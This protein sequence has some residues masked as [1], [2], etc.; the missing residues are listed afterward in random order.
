MREKIIDQ[1]KE[2]RKIWSAYWMSRP[3]ITGADLEVFEHL[4][5]KKSAAYV[6]K[7]IK[8]APRATEIL[9][10]ALSA[11]GFLKKWGGNYKNTKE[12]SLFLVKGSPYYQGDIIRHADNLWKSWG[13]LDEV[14]RTGKPAPRDKNTQFNLE[15]FILGMHNLA[16][17]KARSVISAIGMKGVSRAA[18]IGGGPGT[19]AMEM[20][21]Q[22]VEKVTLFD[23]PET[24]E[25]AK[26]H[27]KRLG[28]KGIDFRSGD[29]LKDS[30][31]N[32]YDLV[33]MSNIHHSNDIEGNN[34]LTGKACESLNMGGRAVI[35][36]FYLKDNRAEPLPSALFSI[37][38]L[39]NTP[40]GRCY[41]E[42][43]LMGFLKHAGLKKIKSKILGDTILLW[44]TRRK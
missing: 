5:T 3:L 35:H 7:K 18:D 44:G 21:K 15:A 29:F 40:G 28:V 11:M 25:I 8:A 6:A 27:I 30:L 23:R 31:G 32:G 4:K 12:A 26:R 9:L 13:S 43:E 16:L 33:F 2:I 14:V 17:F 20:R 42:K 22:G 24:V 37:N 34:V 39:V 10:D 41:T 19:Y 1:A 36:E 38:M